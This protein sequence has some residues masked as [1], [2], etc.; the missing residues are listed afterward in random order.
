MSRRLDEAREALAMFR[1]EREREPASLF[2]AEPSLANE[3]WR[4][5]RSASKRWTGDALE[6]VR[7][8]ALSAS[9]L[10]VDDVRWPD[11]STVDNRA[12]GAVLIAACKAGVL[13]P[14]ASYVSGGPDRHGRPL[15]VF[16]SR[17]YREVV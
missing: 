10:T 2:G 1:H 13:V 6:A 9:H 16:R 11:D 14:T 7:R 4:R 15:R 5:P 17:L 12:R 8:A 3:G